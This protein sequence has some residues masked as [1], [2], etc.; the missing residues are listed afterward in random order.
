[1]TSP[2][3]SASNIARIADLFPAVITESVDADGN[4]VRAIDFDLLR[5]ELSDHV[6]EGPQER[7]Q[8]DW[9]GKRAAA[10]AANAPIAKTLR[11]FREESVEFDATKNLVI[12]GDNLDALKLLQESYLGKIKLIYIDPPYNTGNDFIYED[13]FAETVSEYLER[14]GQRS[15]AGERLVANP[16]SSGRYHSGW[17][18]MMYPRLKLARNLLA[19]DGVLIAAIDD[20][21]HGNLRELLDLVFG[22]DNFLANVVW[23]GGSKNDARFTSQGL[24]YMLIYAR[25]VAGLVEADVRWTEPKKGH[26]QVMEVAREVWDASGHDSAK[27]TPA[28]RKRL[29]EMRADL[30]PAVFRYD[31]IDEAGRPFRTDNLAKPSATGT[32]RYDLAHPVTGLPVKMPR[33]GWRYSPATMADR[34]AQGRVVFGPDHTSTPALK[35]YLDEMDTQA[36]KPVFTQERASAAYALKKLLDSDVFPYTKD[37]GVLAKWINAVTQGDRE[38]VVLDFFAGSG[39]TGHAV[40]SLNAADGGR[41]RFILVQLDEVVNHA[42]YSTIADIA[43]ERLRR[44]GVQLKADAGLLGGALDIGF[45]SLRVDTTNMADVLRTP[46]DTDQQALVGLEDSVKPGRTGEDLLF[47]VLLDWGVDL[48]LP[49]SVDQVEG[50]EVFVVDEGALV[51]C[52]DEDVTPELVRALAKQEPLRAVFRDSGFA[53]DDARI[54]AEQI[55]KELSPA[56]D[57]KAI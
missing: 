28:F 41:R 48:G 49:I 46:D 6:V 56:T 44:A 16:E 37:V 17:L 42:D 19:D 54:N 30:E 25:N 15:D 45:R 36:I 1:M 57:V 7:Y 35:R 8:L 55:F 43:R 12:E 51:A 29:R 5:Q 11:P 52:F 34:I 23:Q 27:A 31:Q 13:A 47:Q 10:F 39:S 24:D 26:A 18:S 33:E 50:C 9:P 4:P 2:D 53:S 20:H 14:S 3:Q 32:S 22:S 38:A 21:E 40:M